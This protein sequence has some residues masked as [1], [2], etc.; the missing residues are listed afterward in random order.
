VQDN[1]KL[2]EKRVKSIVGAFLI[3]VER[4]DIDSKRFTLNRSLLEL[5]VKHYLKNLQALK[6][7]YGIEDN[8]QPQKAAGLITAAIMRFKPVL[9]KNGSDENLFDSDEN[10]VLAAFH[11]LCICAEQGDGK[12]DLKSVMNLWS[13]LEFREWLANF[14]YL[15]K[16][17][18]YTAESLVLSFDALV[19][20]A[21]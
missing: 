15:L 2:E 10:E 9:P 18:N 1:E 5:T 4:R 20:F 19:R 13:K 3:L 11:G 6:N 17:G 16:F 21:K 12:I 7:H 14:L 8:A